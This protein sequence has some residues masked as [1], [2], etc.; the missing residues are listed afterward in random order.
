MDVKLRPVWVETLK[1]QTSVC[2]KSMIAL[3]NTWQKIPLSKWW[4]NHSCTDTSL[5]YRNYW[6]KLIE[7]F[8]NKTKILEDLYLNLIKV[9]FK[10]HQF[11][12]FDPSEN[13]LCFNQL[14]LLFRKFSCHK[15]INIRYYYIC[16]T[17]MF[18][19]IHQWMFSK[20]MYWLQVSNNVYRYESLRTNIFAIKQLCTLFVLQKL[21]C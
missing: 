1:G 14:D 11:L 5:W 16:Q 20:G 15:Q 2:V 18:Q 9:L 19:Y 17:I 8:L 6:L 3:S 4:K 7:V 10:K 21:Y 12:I 13:A